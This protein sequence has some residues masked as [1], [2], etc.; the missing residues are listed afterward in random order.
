MR[1]DLCFLGPM[2]EVY[3]RVPV[4]QLANLFF[5]VWN[6]ACGAAKSTGMMIG[7]RFL[8]GLGG[9]AP[10][11]IG[12][13]VLSDAWRT[14]ERG[15]AIA[16]YSLMPMVGPA[17][18]PIIGG[19]ITENRKIGWRWMFWIV[20]I[21]DACIQVMGL[22]FLRETY[23]P[24]LTKEKRDRLRK[25]TGNERLFT[26]F[27]DPTHTMAHKVKVSLSSAL[28]PHLDTADCP[29]PCSVHG[30]P[31]WADVPRPVPPSQVCGPELHQEDT[32]KALELVV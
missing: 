21:V 23:P 19:F 31:V 6:T 8:A 24:K 1:L 5:L 13:G 4:L 9:S 14:D 16:V 30:I 20:S 11:A 29:V 22:F 15:A 7:F 10:L 3:G 2:S 18:G 26:A 32:A 17:V 25:E 28:H 27:D 12:G